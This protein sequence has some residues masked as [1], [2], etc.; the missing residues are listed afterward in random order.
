MT[1]IISSL[2]EI[3]RNYDALFV[4]LIGIDGIHGAFSQDGDSGAVV[5]NGN[6]EAVAMVIGNAYRGA[7][8]IASPI[9]PI[10][11]HF[12]VSPV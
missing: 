1:Q 4:D 9:K 5:V 6:C 3:S 12:G 7:A 8:S 11:N 10:F 2:S